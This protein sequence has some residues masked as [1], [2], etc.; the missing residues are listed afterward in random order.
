MKMIDEEGKHKGGDEDT[1]KK[2]CP[3][4]CEGWIVLLSHEIYRHEH[5]SNQDSFIQTVALFAMILFTFMGWMFVARN[6]KLPVQDVNQIL[7]VL[8]FLGYIVAVILVFYILCWIYTLLICY[9]KTKKR[10]ESLE[11]IR[12]EIIL[13]NL[14]DSKE[15]REC[16]EEINKMQPKKRLQNL[17][18][19]IL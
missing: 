8:Q 1:Q 14:T 12:K 16:W 4:S 7:S 9:P 17:L 18:S 5:S 6:I 15:I 11:N 2:D 13:G 10:V 3:L 19:I